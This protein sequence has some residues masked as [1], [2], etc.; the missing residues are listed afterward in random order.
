MITLSDERCSVNAQA[1]TYVTS[2][3][4][5]DKSRWLLE[6]DQSEE[7]QRFQSLSRSVPVAINERKRRWGES[8]RERE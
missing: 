3:V 7:R 5:S 8:E 2:L 4:K 6:W 1:K